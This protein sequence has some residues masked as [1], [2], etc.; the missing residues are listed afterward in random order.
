MNIFSPVVLILLLIPLVAEADNGRSDATKGWNLGQRTA[1]DGA[2]APRQPASTTPLAAPVDSSPNTG[3]AGSVSV[4]DSANQSNGDNLRY[5]AGY[6]ARRRGGGPCLG[7][8][9]GRGR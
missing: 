5:G 3:A 9:M 7:R 2:A 6:Q 1:I 8:G 4:T